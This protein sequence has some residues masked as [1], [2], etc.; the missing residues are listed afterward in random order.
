[1]AKNS[2]ICKNLETHT[3]M[4]IRLHHLAIILTLL[5]SACSK[6][7]TPQSQP[8]PEPEPVPE[9]KRTYTIMFYCCGGELDKYNEDVIDIYHW[10]DT[11]IAENINVVGQIKWSEGYHS[12]N[13]DGKGGVSRLKYDHK[14]NRNI[15][16][17]FAD[18]EYHMNCAES[19][20]E[21][22]KW[23]K[24]EAPADEYIMIFAGHGNGYHPAFDRNDTRG[25]IRDDKLTSY[26]GIQDICQACE[27][28]NTHFSLMEMVCCLVNCLE[29]ASELAPY[30]DYYLASCHVTTIS[31]GELYYITEA[32]MQM[33]E[34][35]ARSIA[36]CAKSLVDLTYDYYED[37]K[38]YM[39]IATEHS[40][41]ECSKV[42][43]INEAIRSFVDKVVALYDTELEI[44]SETMRE[45]YGF[46]TED[47]DNALSES[48]YPVLATFSEDYIKRVEWYRLNYMH[49][50]VDIAYRVAEAT[51]DTEIYAAAE[52]IRNASEEAIYHQRAINI[53]SVDKMYYTVT[54]VNKYQYE[55][56]G[57]AEGG[58][59]ETAFDRATGW[60]RLLK[61]NN[62]VYVHSQH[63]DS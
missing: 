9:S 54:L 32:L 55:S 46:T 10:M 53:E 51:H 22:I 37:P 1:M 57:Y 8:E 59:E 15:Y 36:E 24:E 4:R 62:G 12:E 26:L 49:E 7:I 6:E 45:R 39:T 58:Y 25:I 30:V 47:I 56:L 38:M 21:F 17:K 23:A 14:S 48:Y 61:R 20:A 16:S 31:G 19:L 42:D 27:M 2:Y 60:S 18:A 28:T 13:A 34:Y 11:G 41:T 33:E 63:K 43:N 50:I 5:I 40:V 35:D 3:T 44:G 29:Y 52:S